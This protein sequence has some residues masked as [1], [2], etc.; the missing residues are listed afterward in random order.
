[1]GLSE[2][3]KSARS[4]GTIGHGIVKTKVLFSLTLFASVVVMLSRTAPCKRRTAIILRAASED[5][6]N[7]SNSYQDRTLEAE[8]HRI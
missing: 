1:M 6:S 8:K 3:A 2:P 4:R 7:R 5:G